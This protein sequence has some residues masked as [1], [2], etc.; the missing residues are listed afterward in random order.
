MKKLL[1]VG[2]SLIFLTFFVGCSPADAITDDIYLSDLYTNDVF[3]AINGT[4]NLGSPDHAWAAGYFDELYSSNSTIY[5][6][7]LTLLDYLASCNLTGSAGPAGPTGPQGIP[8]SSGPEGP[9]GDTGEQ[10]IQGPPGE[11]GSPGEQG[12]QGIQG[13]PGLQGDAG[14]QGIPGTQGDKGDTGEQ[15]IQGPPGEQG[16]PGPE[17]E[18]IVVLTGNRANST[19]TLANCTGLAFNAEANS[20]Y[21]IEGFIVWDSSVAT[22]GLKISASVT[23]SPL[24]NSG[25][26][27]SDAVA[28]TP[29]SS[30]WNAN[31]VVTTTSASPFTNDSCG[32]LTALLVTNSNAGT[33]QLRFAAETTGTITI[34]AGSTIRYRKVAP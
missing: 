17:S 4:Y 12:I 8:G 28:G 7:D 22:V 1:L 16:P 3:P 9:Q 2:S 31:D 29:D 10:G 27:I 34:Q 13:I 15:G 26:F 14:P 18:T 24:I 6:G 19:T 20:K 33:W 30:S 11:Q 25:F 32:N 23:N 5:I 21:I